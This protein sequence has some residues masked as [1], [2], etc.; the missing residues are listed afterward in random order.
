M[1][2][3]GLLKKTLI[4][5]EG[6]RLKLYQCTAGKLTIGIGR[7][8]EDNGISKD[9]SD[10]MLN[11]DINGVIAGLESSLTLYN[12]LSPIRQL[13]LA[14]MAFNLGKTRFMGFKKFIAALA[15]RDYKTAAKEMIESKWAQ[16]V[17]ERAKRLEMMMLTGEYSE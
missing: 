9:E 13:V 6:E 4:R 12:K 10:L 3:I 11:N 17:G 5:D 8:I 2:D 14:N 7:N 16:Q 1:L 15:I